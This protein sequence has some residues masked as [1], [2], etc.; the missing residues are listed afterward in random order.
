MVSL[1]KR[2]AWLAPLALFA[3][4]LAGYAR[5]LRPTFGWGDSSE[6]AIAVRFLGVGH[7]PGYP[8]FIMLG[9]AFTWL[10]LGDFA[11]RV[12]LYNA[13]CGAV[14]AVLAYL[15][16]SRLTRSRLAAF[17]AA[18]CFAFSATLWD[19]TSDVD[20]HTLHACFAAGAIWALLRW[21]EDHQERFLSWAALLFGVGLTNHPLIGLLAP[22]A[23]YLIVAERGW[24]FLANPGRVLRCAALIAL[25]LLLYLYV[26]IRGAANPPPGVNNPHTFSEAIAQITAPQYRGV[27]FHTPIA[28]VARKAAQYPHRLIGE[29]GYPGVIAGLIGMVVLWRRDRRFLAFA[30]MGMAVTI[31]Y[32]VN[33]AIFDIYQYYIQTYLLWATFI[34]FGF[35]GALR[36]LSRAIRARQRED[37]PLAHL[38]QGALL[39]VVLL[40][41]PLFEFAVN[42]PRVNASEDY[43]AEDYARAALAQVEPHALIVGDWWAIA[44]LAYLKYVEGARGDV[45][46]SSAFSFSSAKAFEAA[47]EADS[48]RRF[49]AVYACEMI[50]HRLG[51]V[52]RRYRVVQDGPL[53]RVLVDPPDPRSLEAECSAAPLASFGSSLKLLKAGLTPA[54]VEEGGCV[55]VDY[56]WTTSGRLPGLDTITRIRDAGGRAIAVE[57]SGILQGLYPL[58]RWEA[59]QAVREHHVIYIESE[60]SPGK[61][62]VTLKV[63][64]QSGGKATLPCHSGDVVRTGEFVVGRFEVAA[65]SRRHGASPA[66]ELASGGAA[67]AEGARGPAG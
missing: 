48:L 65:R 9:H 50:T 22:A 60:L 56:V 5:T 10:P 13:T 8:T 23:V 53:L 15:I 47:M 36:A 24:R 46:L 63:R 32:A 42:L 57:T 49:P 28:V 3:L 62:Q 59:G 45:T 40:T 67:K 58:D 25:P 6:L 33:Y 66:G 18:T 19:A 1:S 17:A 37:G 14:A 29:V 30:L 52:Q 7:S 4:A 26:P 41:I 12:N 16:C 54:R 51:E 43:A 44:P 21:R 34:A 55:Q 2:Q 11:H 61:Y 39:A 38:R 27:V 20:V 31:L 64:E 35:D